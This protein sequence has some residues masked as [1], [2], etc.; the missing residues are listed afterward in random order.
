MSQCTD[1]TSGCEESERTAIIG[2]FEVLLLTFWFVFTSYTTIT[3]KKKGLLASTWRD[4][5]KPSFLIFISQEHPRINCRGA[6]GNTFVWTPLPLTSYMPPVLTPD[7]PSLLRDVY[8]ILLAS[9]NTSIINIYFLFTE[10]TYSMCISYFNINFEKSRPRQVNSAVALR[11]VK[12][13]DTFERNKRMCIHG[14]SP[15][16]SHTTIV[17]QIVLNPPWW[18]VLSKRILFV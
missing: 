3:T 6:G 17:W 4:S 12:S 18:I 11:V 5:S 16:L 14:R 15:F 2:L 13:H 7:V 10:V 9:Q 1:T 8:L